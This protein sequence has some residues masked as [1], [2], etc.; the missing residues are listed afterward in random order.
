MCAGPAALGNPCVDPAQCQSAQCTDGACCDVAVC[1]AGQSC[2]VPGHAGQCNPVPTPTPGG[3]G[4]CVGDCNGN[5]VVTVDE[6]IIMVNIALDDNGTGRCVAGD[7]SGDGHITINE[8]IAAVNNALL[9]CPSSVTPTPSVTP[10]G[11]GAIPRRAAGASVGLAQGLRALP[12]VLSSITQLAGGGGAA[13][14]V[15]EGAAAAQPCVGG[16]TRDF[17]CTQTFPTSSPRN[18]TLTFSGCVLNTTGGGTVRLDGTITAQSTE[19]GP[20][21]VCDF[22]PLSLSTMSLSNVQLVVKNAAAVTTLSAQFDLTGSLT[23]TPDLLSACKVSGLTMTLNGT[24]DSQSATL[25]ETLVFQSTDVRLDISQFSQSCV[26]VIYQMTL[27][28]SASFD[29]DSL[30]SVLSGTFNNFVFGDNTTSGSELITIDGQ[31]SSTCLGATVT[32]STPAALSI[33]PGMVCPA[34]GAVLV[35]ASGITDRLNYTASGGIDIDLGNN[36]T[37][38]EMLASCLDPQLYVCPGG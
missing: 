6:L 38:D 27:N 5:C 21:A 2:N 9:E 15:A 10:G 8:I 11:D 14:D 7:V 25:S 18:Y 13:A 35:T 3:C 4:S 28:G 17:V 12:L 22:P 26:P 33:S 19:T 37:I 1:A 34:A 32:F 20:L 24:M 36:S 23:A 16:G 31:L 29:V 30:G